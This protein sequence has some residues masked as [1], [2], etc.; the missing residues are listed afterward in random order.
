VHLDSTYDCWEAV[1]EPANTGAFHIIR[2][3]IN[4]I[5]NQYTRGVTSIRLLKE[6]L[7]TTHQGL[8]F[9]PFSPYFETFN[10]AIGR[11]VSSGL[12]KYWHE[13]DIKSNRNDFPEDIGP[14]VL[15]LEQLEICFY[16]CLIP[17]ILCFGVF[18]IEISLPG[19][20]LLLHK[21]TSIY[22]KFIMKSARSAINE[23]LCFYD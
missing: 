12:V 18:F 11:L 3:F 7:A 21:L 13:N 17:L 5:N 15:T 1:A 4:M 9:P 20:K 23:L 10:D 19:L 16:A 2:F 8:S 6:N 14:Q 22:M